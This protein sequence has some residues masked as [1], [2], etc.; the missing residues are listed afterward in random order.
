LKEIKKNLTASPRV[1][2]FVLIADDSPTQRKLFE[3]L[4][5]R[6]GVSALVVGSCVEVLKQLELCSV[7]LILMDWEM[8]DIDGLVCAQMIRSLEKH[9]QKRIPII[10]VTWNHA[11]G[12]RERCLNCGLDD[13]LPK[14]FTF[15]ELDEKIKYWLAKK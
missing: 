6:L 15:E 10:A 5:E 12:D 7:D 9:R 14:P 8:P 3:L 13:Y 4:A 11:P 2:P 1:R